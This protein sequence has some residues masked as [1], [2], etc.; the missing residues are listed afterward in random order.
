MSPD[1]LKTNILAI[2]AAGFLI[3]LTG[4]G[5]YLFKDQITGNIRF[6]MPIPPIAVG[7]Y[8]FVVNLFNYYKGKPPEGVAFALREILLGSAVAAISF[9]VFALLLIII[10]DVFKS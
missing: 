10:V 2:T 7:A 3:L 9:G 8:I 4:L 1:L 5:L 6:F